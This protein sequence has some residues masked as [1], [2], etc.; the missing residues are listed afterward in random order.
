MVTYRSGDY[1]LTLPD[2]L[3]KELEKYQ[4]RFAPED[5]EQVAVEN[6]L[7]ETKENLVCIRMLFHEALGHPS[8]EEPKK[9]DSNRLATIMHHIPGW[10]TVGIQRFLKYG[11]ARA[12]R[13]KED[14]KTPEEGFID[15]PEQMELPFDKE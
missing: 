5:T 14:I 15:V 2:H 12:W 9:S 10:E 3:K 13:R 7:A 11:S 1:S 8:Y 6:F 4:Q